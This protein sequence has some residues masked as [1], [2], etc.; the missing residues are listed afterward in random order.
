M[1]KSYA[2]FNSLGG[3][4]LH[5]MVMSFAAQRLNVKPKISSPAKV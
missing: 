1:K 2:G 5:F 4:N 3:F